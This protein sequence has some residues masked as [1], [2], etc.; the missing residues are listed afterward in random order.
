ML[1][2]VRR[3]GRL[4]KRSWTDSEEG[5]GGLAPGAKPRPAWK[6]SRPACNSPPCRPPKAL[7]CPRRP[8]HLA[9]A[10]PCRR[11]AGTP[12]FRTTSLS[13]RPQAPKHMY[14]SVDEACTHVDAPAFRLLA[15]L[16]DPKRAV[17]LASGVSPPVR[18]VRAR[19][20][21]GPPPATPPP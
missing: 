20:A 21:P 13:A 14:I 15:A 12:R 3:Y 4:G 18:C 9:R 19:G 10:P 5:E 17:L 7:R 16:Y 6:A 1:R 8:A 2:T 11:S